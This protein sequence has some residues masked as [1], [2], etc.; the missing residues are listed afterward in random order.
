MPPPINGQQNTMN[1]VMPPPARLPP[2]QQYSPMYNIQNQFQVPVTQQQPPP[3]DELENPQLEPPKPPISGFD[4]NLPPNSVVEAKPYKVDSQDNVVQ[5]IQSYSQEHNQFPNPMQPPR[6]QPIYQQNFGGQRMYAKNAHVM[7]H[8]AAAVPNP[9]SYGV[10]ESG[11]HLQVK[12][13]ST[14]TVGY[15]GQQ[16]V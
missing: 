2:A 5:G 6:G 12:P 4:L 8:S 13:S 9:M 14:S 15:P 16:T 7:Q 10:V 1:P 3:R 11:P